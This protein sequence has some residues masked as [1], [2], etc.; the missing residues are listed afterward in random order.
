MTPE[1]RSLVKNEVKR[2][3]SRKFIAWVA[4]FGS[5]A[6]FTGV[7]IRTCSRAAWNTHEA[8]MAGKAVVEATGAL[9]I[10]KDGWTYATF[11]FVLVTLI[12]M[13]SN[14]ADRWMGL[15]FNGTGTGDSPPESN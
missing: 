8:I 15:R 14:L 6:I 5:W 7:F 1:A 4:M 13:G 12:Y 11:A 10:L 3:T 2:V 9:A